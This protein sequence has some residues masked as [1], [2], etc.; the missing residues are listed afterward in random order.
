MNAKQYNSEFKKF[1]KNHN[2]LSDLLTAEDLQRYHQLDFPDNVQIVHDALIEKLKED[3]D[4]EV[5][6]PVRYFKYLLLNTVTGVKEFYTKYAFISNKGNLYHL[7]KTPQLDVKENDDEY[8]QSVV[9]L[10]D[11]SVNFSVNRAVATSFVPLP[12]D[13]KAYGYYALEVKHK[14]DRKGD[15]DFRNLEW[16]AGNQNDQTVVDVPNVV[17]TV[18][19]DKP[20][21]NVTSTDDRTGELLSIN[22]KPSSGEHP[23]QY[24]IRPIILEV[25][26]PGDYYGVRLIR[27]SPKELDD[28]LGPGMASAAEHA[29][30]LN[31]TVYG[32]RWS[33]ATNDEVAQ[34]GALRVPA[35][36]RALL[37]EYAAGHCMN[38]LGTRVADGHMILIEGDPLE[39]EHLGL[40]Y[41]DILKVCDGEKEAH[42]GYTFR[43][44]DEEEMLQLRTAIDLQTTQTFPQEAPVVNFIMGKRISDGHLILFCTDQEIELLGWDPKLVNKAARKRGVPVYGYEFERVTDDL[45][46]LNLRN[47]IATQIT[48]F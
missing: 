39:T 8:Q 47:L 35:K 7:R 14:N 2:Q 10:T 1:I 20:V 30:N 12:K 33:Y 34:Y 41:S 27:S 17:Q 22:S 42:K 36:L 46:A 48:Q 9:Q 21:L 4:Y 24:H 19:E 6:V 26:I 32:C 5:W 18:R 11:G 16:F 37:H 28:L 31:L 3:P 25:M 40:N 43:R 13:L 15:N 38:I 29:A 44:V 23:E 45:T